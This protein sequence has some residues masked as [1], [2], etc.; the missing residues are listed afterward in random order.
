[1]QRRWAIVATVTTCL[2]LGKLEQRSVLQPILGQFQFGPV[3]ELVFSRIPNLS[4]L[5]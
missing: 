3:K 5:T 4:L 2:L 1:M